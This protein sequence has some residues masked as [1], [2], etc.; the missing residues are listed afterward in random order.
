MVPLNERKFETTMDRKSGI[1][2]LRKTRINVINCMIKSA[3][4]NPIP[5]NLLRLEY[6]S[7][8]ITKMLAAFIR[9]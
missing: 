1:Y 9:V 5:L 3:S 6:H 8:A 2:P 7:E 4:A